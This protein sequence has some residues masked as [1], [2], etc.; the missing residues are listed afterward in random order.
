MCSPSDL[1]PEE[2]GFEALGDGLELD[3]L[4]T[5]DLMRVNTRKS[6]Y[7]FRM[8]DPADRSAMM[9]KQGVN[10][11]AVPVRIMGC[12]MGTSSRIDPRRLFCGGSLEYTHSGGARTH[13]T[14]AI[15]EITVLRHAPVT[16]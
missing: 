11:P 9:W 8:E 3:T 4:A 2:P 5:G 6:T 13:I 10:L 7:F 12:V 14:T 1:P 15:V 16:N